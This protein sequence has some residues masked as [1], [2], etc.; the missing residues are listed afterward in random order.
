MCAKKMNS[1]E[2]GNESSVDVFD[3]ARQEKNGVETVIYAGPTLH[4]RV[5]I[6]SSVYRNGVPS[7]VTDLMT[8][9]PE[10]GKMIVPVSMFPDFR[11]EIQEEGTEAHRLYRYLMTLR[12]DGAEVRK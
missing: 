9:V 7:Y 5:L 6:G 8:K 10:I 2:T 4:R 12:F 3:G 1:E 11:K